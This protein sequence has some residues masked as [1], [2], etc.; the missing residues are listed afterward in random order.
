MLYNKNKF[1]CTYTINK[2][3]LCIF[4]HYNPLNHQTLTI[5]RTFSL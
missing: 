2:R 3:T 5:S 1:T 4:V